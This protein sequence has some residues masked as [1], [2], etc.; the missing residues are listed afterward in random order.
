ME[1]SDDAH[2]VQLL[3]IGVSTG[4]C[5]DARLAAGSPIHLLSWR[6]QS[7]HHEENAERD[8]EASE[9]GF[10]FC[11]SDSNSF[12]R[13]NGVPRQGFELVLI[14]GFPAAPEG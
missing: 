5:H 11:L 6:A 8:S 9:L 3:A 7:T 13:L 14:R 4:A 1:G 10:P 12:Y 2:G